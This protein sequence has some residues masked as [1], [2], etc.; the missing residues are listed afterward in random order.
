[1][2][3]T[4]SWS[5]SDIVGGFGGHTPGSRTALVTEIRARTE[6]TDFNMVEGFWSG[7]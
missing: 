3:F 2:K 4:L 7:C 5:N 6:I 1:M